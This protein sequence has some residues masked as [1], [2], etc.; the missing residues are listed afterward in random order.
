[1][2]TAS[3]FRAAFSA[4]GLATFVPNVV[5]A[6]GLSQEQ[7][8]WLVNVGLPR[9]TAPFLDFGGKNESSLPSMAALFQE[10]DRA[11]AERY[12]VIGSNGNGDPVVLD[13]AANGA[14]AYLNHDN[15]MCRILINSSVTQLAECL[16]AFKRLIDLAQAAN[17]EDAYLD[18]DIPSDAL[19]EF[20]E[21]VRACDPA[22]LEIDTMWTD[23][24]QS[25]NL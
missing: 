22:A 18:G 21:I 16:L 8:V 11:I 7:A 20:V 9:S 12:R 17:G 1:L 10:R 3:E 25:F 2:I 15:N 23:E 24:V 5:S 13:L 19:N 6:I 14:V 4:D